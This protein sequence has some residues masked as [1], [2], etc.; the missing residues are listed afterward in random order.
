MEAKTPTELRSMEI[1][2]LQNE[3]GIQKKKLETK[4]E[5][6]QRLEDL[7]LEWQD[8]V[9]DLT[10]AHEK[11]ISLL[12]NQVLELNEKFQTQKISRP[13][14]IQHRHRRTPSEAETESPDLPPALVE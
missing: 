3:L 13:L 12:Q 10:T 5:I 1:E 7:V 14:V 9:N 6:I 8:K 4:D 11:E 2:N